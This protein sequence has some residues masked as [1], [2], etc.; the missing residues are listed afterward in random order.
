MVD[1]LVVGCRGNAL[2]VVALV[3]RRWHGEFSIVYRGVL[4]KGP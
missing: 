1:R 2:T 4:G 3:A